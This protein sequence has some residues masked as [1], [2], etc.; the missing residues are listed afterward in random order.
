MVR[1]RLTEI[2]YFA[3]MEK[4]NYLKLENIMRG[5][6]IEISKREGGGKLTPARARRINESNQCISLRIGI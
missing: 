4:T 6:V 5:R 3:E 2:V 1:K